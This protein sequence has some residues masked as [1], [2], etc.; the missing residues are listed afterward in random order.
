MGH[1]QT[2]QE[3]GARPGE[4]TTPV[5]VFDEDGGE[6]FVTRKGDAGEF[7]VFVHCIPGAAIYSLPPGVD[8]QLTRDELS[9][10]TKHLRMFAPSRGDWVTPIMSFDGAP[11]ELGPIVELHA[12]EPLA[13]HRFDWGGRSCALVVTKSVEPILEVTTGQVYTYDH[14][15]VDPKPGLMDRLFGRFFNDG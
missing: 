15:W 1:D 3:S 11:L 6:R 5:L 14:D 4:H 2:V 9:L 8:R 12:P 13:G 10:A 7:G